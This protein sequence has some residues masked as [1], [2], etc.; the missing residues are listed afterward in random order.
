MCKHDF[1]WRFEIFCE[2]WRWFGDFKVFVPRYIPYFLNL[3]YVVF[4][5]QDLLPHQRTLDVFFYVFFE[6]LLILNV[7]NL[8]V[9]FSVEVESLFSFISGIQSAAWAHRCFLT[10]GFSLRRYFCQFLKI[11]V[12]LLDILSFVNI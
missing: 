11:W 7:I 2:L 12:L 5:N 6:F 1:R 10:R 3:I 8:W 4:G 9:L